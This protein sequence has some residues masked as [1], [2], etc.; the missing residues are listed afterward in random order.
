M[1]LCLGLAGCTGD[2]DIVDV[3]SDTQSSATDTQG[4]SE[5]TKKP[6]YTTKEN[7]PYVELNPWTFKYEDGIAVRDIVINTSKGGDDVTVVQ[8]TDI[9]VA[10]VNDEDLQDETIKN[11]YN[12]RS[13]G[14][15]GGKHW[16]NALACLDWAKDADQ[17]VIT[18]DI[19]DYLTSETVQ[20]VNQ[21]IFNAYDNIMACL[22]NHEVVK[23][24]GEENRYTN[25]KD[26]VA[27]RINTFKDSWANTD[28]DGDVFYSKKVLGDKVM[29]IQMD[30]G[31][32]GGFWDSQVE[33]FRED[34]AMARENGYAVLLFYHIPICTDNP[35]YEKAVSKKL[36]TYDESNAT[37]DFYNKGATRFSAGASGEI[38]KL[39]YENGDIIK[40]TF[41]G[42]LHNDYYTEIL[43]S[44]PS[45]AQ[46]RIPQYLIAATA[47]DNGH[48]LRIT[49]K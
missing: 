48:A 41:C 27:G 9:H 12:T 13:F 26:I 17:I 49:V 18:G 39:I 30:N 24:M 8:L 34:L 20:R 42:H 47:Y 1:C 4:E 44:S 25:W 3:S 36:G 14:K 31:S 21:Y 19:Y 28:G 38:C 2:A 16:T 35:Q 10:W 46:T 40:G 11:T 15:N 23:A 37:Y 43:A 45:G 29:L 22:G 32:F 7:E 33:R 6:S 5:T